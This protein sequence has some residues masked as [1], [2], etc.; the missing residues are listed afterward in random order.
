MIK[1]V[2][3]RRA[4]EETKIQ[5]ICTREPPPFF[6]L[7][8]F[9][10]TAPL[11]IMTW[12]M[13]YS[14][15]PH[16]TFLSPRKTYLYQ[17]ITDRYREGLAKYEKRGWCCFETIPSQDRSLSSL[18]PP[19]GSRLLCD[20]KTWKM[21]LDVSGVEASSAVPDYV[22]ECA[23]FRISERRSGGVLELTLLR[24]SLLF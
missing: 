13:S 7:Q 1:I 16:I 5:I 14:L 17:E 19:G 24:Q 21:A 22:L 9:Y 20:S 10:T 8:G 23:E 2:T 4:E 18:V 11:N 3:Y 12:N 6:I 15:F